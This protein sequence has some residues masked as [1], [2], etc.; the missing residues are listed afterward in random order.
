MELAV[1]KA[2]LGDVLAKE[3][4]EKAALERLLK[5]MEQ[6]EGELLA[7]EERLAELSSE[8]THFEQQIDA[9]ETKKQS[10]MS[11][12]SSLQSEHTSERQAY[13]VQRH[14]HTRLEVS[15]ASIDESLLEFDR[16][17]K[18]TGS[19]IEEAK[20]RQGSLEREWKEQTARM[21]RAR[22]DIEA[23]DIALAAVY[24]QRL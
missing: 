13:E 23:N 14:E 20:I 1:Q 7:I 10:A 5:E 6:R 22:Q 9:I 21:E 8:K 12:L 18:N 11:V 3:E 17:T 24:D 16:V 2:K 19:E 4:A 15:I